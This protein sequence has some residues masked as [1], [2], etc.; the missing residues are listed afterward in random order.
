MNDRRLAHVPCAYVLLL[1]GALLE[2]LTAFGAMGALSEAS[3]PR[4]RQV[5]VAVNRALAW[6]VTQQEEN[7][8]F[9]PNENAEPGVTSLCLLA[10]LACGHDPMAKPYGTVIAKGVDFV[11]SCQKSNGL[12]VYLQP[13]DVHINHYPSHTAAY[14][15]AISGL[16]LSECY[17]MSLG[18]RTDTMRSVIEDALKYSRSKQ[19]EW[20]PSEADKGGWRYY[21][22]AGDANSDLSLTSWQLMF[23][24]SAKSAGFE[25]PAI[26]IDDG[27]A[28]VKRCFDAGVPN[29]FRYVSHGPYFLFESRAM[30]GAGIM[31][32]S[33]G[34]THRTEMAGRAGRWLLERPFDVYKGTCPNFT[35]FHY[36]AFYCSQAMFQ[37]GEPYWGR[38]YPVMADTLLANQSEDGQ[39]PADKGG[40]KSFGGTFRTAMAVLALSP[41]YQVLPIFQR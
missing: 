41:P 20:K 35:S 26:W 7:G 4:S 40:E 39:W 19:V 10:L 9:G 25:V 32:L 30:A 12:I 29:T 23:L 3:S 11:L 28:Y 14:T 8:V 13:E 33:L 18:M 5:D 27:L 31:S 6:L 37:L 38:F 17:G 34:G 15:H 24:R 36:G 2:S 16:L 1:A 21:V 22:P